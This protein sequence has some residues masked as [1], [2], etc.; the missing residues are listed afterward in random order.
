MLTFAKQ[1]VCDAL[2]D[3]YAS[4][5]AHLDCEVPVPTP[6]GTFGP[7]PFGYGPT[8][9]LSSRSFKRRLNPPELARTVSEI[10]RRLIGAVKMLKRSES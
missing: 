9:R 1:V 6:Q 7:S 4:R 2:G 5:K 3:S 8:S 10:A